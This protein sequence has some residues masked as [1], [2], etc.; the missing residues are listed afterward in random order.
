[1][2][3][4]KATRALLETIAAIYEDWTVI[5]MH[6]VGLLRSSII[7]SVKTSID[8]AKL[9]VTLELPTYEV[10]IQGGRRPG[11]KRPPFAV[12]LKWVIAKLGSQD[13]N[14]RAWAICSAISRRGIRARPF[15][16]KAIAATLEEAAEK[17]P[18]TLKL[19]VDPELAKMFHSQP[20]P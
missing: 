16:Q 9:S 20:N 7:K 6:R 4:N 12:I 13:A 3:D 17:L 19:V 14:K 18:K 15:M 5:E 1:M 11:A 10:F 2:M 8:V